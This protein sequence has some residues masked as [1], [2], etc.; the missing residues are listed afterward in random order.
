[1]YLP[2]GVYIHVSTLPQGVLNTITPHG[3]KM[4]REAINESA[5]DVMY[6]LSPKYGPEVSSTCILTCAVYIRRLENVY[7]VS[8]ASFLFTIS[9]H[10][11]YSFITVVPFTGHIAC[12][13][14]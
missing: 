12:I 7:F 1:M 3:V 8:K 10:P 5:I 11:Q 14:C 2:Y 4:V 9:Q 13:A 6:Y